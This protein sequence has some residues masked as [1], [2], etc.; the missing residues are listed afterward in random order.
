MHGNSAR[1]KTRLGV[2]S[3]LQMLLEGGS[4]VWLRRSMQFKTN[5]LGDEF[6]LSTFLILLGYAITVH[7]SQGMSISS[8]VIIY[9]KDGF[10]PGLVYVAFPRISDPCNLSCTTSTLR[11]ENFLPCIDLLER[12][13]IL[14]AI[15]I[16][17]DLHPMIFSNNARL[18]NSMDVA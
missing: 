2:V 4:L 12:Y 16:L 9:L 6:Y 5:H 17:A 18:N 13:L 11:T 10:S 8:K 3:S 1:F 15:L 7:R 14:I